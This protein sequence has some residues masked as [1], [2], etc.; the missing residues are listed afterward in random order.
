MNS[1][2]FLTLAQENYD[3]SRANVI[4]SE[5]NLK[6]CWKQWLTAELVHMFNHIEGDYRLETDIHYPAH[7]QTSSDPAFLQYQASKGATPVGEKRNGSRC[8]FSVTTHPQTVYCEI[9]GANADLFNKNKDLA[10]WL[11]DIERIEALKEA[12]PNLLI[13]SIFVF[14]GAFSSDEMKMFQ[15]MDNNS[16]CIYVLDTLLTGSTSIARLSQLNRNGD[17][18][19][20]VGTFSL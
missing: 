1:Q 19:I 6:N 17:K 18:R 14:Y 3:F 10:K 8:D 7:Q 13:L 12:N 4:L 15:P 11:A 20:C 2:T 9:R 16:R 5:L